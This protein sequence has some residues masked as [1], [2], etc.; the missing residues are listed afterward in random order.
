MIWSLV[1]ATVLNA[2]AKEPAPVDARIRPASACALMLE[3][4]RPAEGE[5][6][7]TQH[8]LALLEEFGNLHLPIASDSLDLAPDTLR[9]LSSRGGARDTLTSARLLLALSHRERLVGDAGEGAAVLSYL[10]ELQDIVRGYH[11]RDVQDVKRWMRAYMKISAFGA[12][13]A[14]LSLIVP[15]DTILSGGM[16]ALLPLRRVVATLRSFRGHLQSASELIASI[17]LHPRAGDW[18]HVH[19]VTADGENVDV[20]VFTDARG[21]PRL[22]SF[23]SR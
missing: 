21:E 17:G 18:V 22:A 19:A 13:F 3:L 20:L 6:D 14:G 15:Q 1:L 8:A 5:P 23:V 10:V 4:A 16:I 12:G 11:R 9:V 7:R 2:G